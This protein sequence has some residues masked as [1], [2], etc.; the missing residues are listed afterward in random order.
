MPTFSH[1]RV[2]SST[3]ILSRSQA[4]RCVWKRVIF[5]YLMFVAKMRAWAVFQFLHQKKKN[6]GS[7]LNFSKKLIILTHDCSNMSWWFPDDL[8]LQIAFPHRQESVS[9]EKNVFWF[10]GISSTQMDPPPAARQILLQFSSEPIEQE[11]QCLH[12]WNWPSALICFRVGSLAGSLVQKILK[13]NF[14]FSCSWEALPDKTRQTVKLP[15]AHPAPR[16]SN[17]GVSFVQEE[18]SRLMMLVTCCKSVTVLIYHPVIVYVNHQMEKIS[19]S[20][21]VVPP[22]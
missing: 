2:F 20:F 14:D 8:D 9:V 5:C 1:S 6:G 21:A 3:K 7:T 4:Q 17:K 12:L 19:L 22:S 15:W 10:P 13:S 11:F 16:Q 18:C